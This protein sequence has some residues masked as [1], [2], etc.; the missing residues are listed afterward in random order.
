MNVPEVIRQVDQAGCPLVCITGGE[1]LL[2]Q[3]VYP[4]AG[5]LLEKGYRVLVETNGSMPVKL[6]PE[7]VVRIVD[8]KCPG[9]G[10]SE[11]V[12]WNN[13]GCLYSHDEVKFVVSSRD[14]YEW[15]KSVVKHFDLCDRVTV[16]VS[17]AW[18]RVRL[19]EIGKWILDDRLN[20]RLQPQLH[21]L[22]AAGEHG[23]PLSRQGRAPVFK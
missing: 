21:K 2:Q 19:S 9:S 12:D 20:V 18:N 23:A 16:L 1:P 10:M 11:R 14:D 6:L 8:V 7:D 15:A 17:A 13:L 5:T 22:I 3:E 4:L